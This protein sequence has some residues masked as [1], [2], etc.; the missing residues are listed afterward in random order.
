MEDKTGIILAGG[1]S[2][3]MGEDKGLMSLEGK[4]M[5]Q[6]VID[7]VLTQ[8]DQIC[9]ISNNSDYQ[10]F[11]WPV[12]TDLVKGKGPLGGIVT[13]LS[14]SRTRQNWILSCD[15]PF[16]TEDL[17]VMLMNQLNGFDAAIPEKLNRTHPLI[18]AYDLSALPTYKVAL[19]QDNLKL[20]EA[21]KSLNINYFDANQ[22]DVRNFKNINAREDL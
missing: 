16:I 10:I 1:E 3:R 4:P 5:I 17:L 7:V 12:H 13:G 2:S 9:I 6:Y 14:A 8:T 20:S 11:G 22:F 15:S 21:N 18:A 19:N